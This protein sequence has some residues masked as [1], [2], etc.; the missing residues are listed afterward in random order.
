MGKIIDYLIHGTIG[1]LWG[2]ININTSCH[3]IKCSKRHI[4]QNKQTSISTNLYNY[5]KKIQE[6]PCNKWSNALPRILVIS[7]TLFANGSHLQPSLENYRSLCKYVTWL[8]RFLDVCLSPAQEPRG[9]SLM[10]GLLICLKA[11]EPL[12]IIHISELS[13]WLTRCHLKP[14]LA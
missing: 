6:W 8:G 3:I 2:G 9:Q 4:I 14:H 7:F 12:N 1:Y 13:T 11:A 5:L 10:E